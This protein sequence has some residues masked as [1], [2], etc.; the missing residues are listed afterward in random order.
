MILC[1]QYSSCISK[2]SPECMNDVIFKIVGGI[3]GER[4]SY[5]K[6]QYSQKHHVSEKHFIYYALQTIQNI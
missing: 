4:H 3:D 1:F 2:D 6:S 5:Y